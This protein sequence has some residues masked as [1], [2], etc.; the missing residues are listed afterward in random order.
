METPNP[1]TRSITAEPRVSVVVPAYNEAASL[2]TLVAEVQGALSLETWEL[3]VV[4]DG[5]RDE[6]ATTLEKLAAEEP[7]LRAFRM[8]GNRGQSAALAAGIARARGEIVVTLDADL[9]NDPADIP[10]LLEALEGCDVVSGVRVKRRDTWL[11]RI[12]SRIA[13]GVRRGVL[14][15][16]ISDVGCSLKAYRRSVLEAVPPFNGFHRFLPALAQMGGARVRELPV[17]HRPRRHGESSYGVRNR[18]ARGVVDLLGVRWLKRRYVDPREARPLP[19]PP[20]RSG[21]ATPRA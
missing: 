20:L 21:A 6:T 14:D 15:D 7:R 3:V 16:G 11:R 12:A 8:P 5:S 17:H 18:L 2:P 13:N 10:R 1:T 9:Q 4:D 19:E